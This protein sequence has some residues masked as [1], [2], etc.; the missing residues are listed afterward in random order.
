M[1]AGDQLEEMLLGMAI[2]QEAV[3]RRSSDVIDWRASIEEPE[4]Y[5]VGL[6]QWRHDSV[7]PVAQPLLV[8]PFVV[9]VGCYNDGVQDGRC[10]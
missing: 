4:V 3:F 8:L 2:A 1:R 5:G 9:A 7:P 10:C 6:R